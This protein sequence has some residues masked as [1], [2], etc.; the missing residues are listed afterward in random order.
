MQKLLYRRMLKKL[1]IRRFLT[2]WSKAPKLHF[3]KI[4]DGVSNGSK[5]T[6]QINF[7]L[8]IK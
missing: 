3:G 7:F 2:S 1:N 6:K 8:F 5:G 4:S